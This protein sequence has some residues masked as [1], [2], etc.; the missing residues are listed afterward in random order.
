[1]ILGIKN[2][3]VC[4]NQVLEKINDLVAAQTP[5]V[6]TLYVYFSLFYDYCINLIKSDRF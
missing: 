3:G 5:V 2:K 6:D 1:M 4:M